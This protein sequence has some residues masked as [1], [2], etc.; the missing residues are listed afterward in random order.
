MKKSAQWI[1]G[2]VAA[3]VI[4]III[5]ALC[6]PLVINPNDYKNTITNLVRE[7]TGRTLRLPG[8]IKL[9]VSPSLD[10]IFALGEMELSSSPDFPDTP[11]LSSKS[12][13]TQLALWPLLAHK[14]LKVTHITLHGVN[15][16]LLR[17][18]QGDANWEDLGGSRQSTIQKQGAKPT[19]KQ[20]KSSEQELAGLD[21]GGIEATD[22]NVDF[23]DKQNDR[24]VS[25][26][27]L[28]LKIG[29][30]RPGQPFPLMTDFNVIMAAG[31]HKPLTAKI[32]SQ[33]DLT[34]FPDRQH[35]V[36]NNLKLKGTLNGAGLPIELDLKL[37]ADAD[38]NLRDEKIE[39]KN[40]VVK[41]GAMQAEGSLSLAGFSAPRASGTLRIPEFSPRAQ[42]GVLGLTLPFKDIK[43]LSRISAAMEFALD[44]DNLII[45]K[46]HLE[47]DDTSA[48]GTAAV[49]NLSDPS[50][51]LALH[52]NTI[53]LDR[54]SSKQPDK[55]TQR[56]SK[57]T[58][59]PEKRN[60]GT[61]KT[62]IPVDSIR[63]L[64]FNTDIIIDRLKAAKLTMS[65]VRIRATGKNG[66]IRLDPLS[67]HLYDG[68]L[69]AKGTIDARPD[70]PRMHLTKVLEG[71]RLGPLFRDWTGTEE[72]KGK[73]D[74]H[75]DV[76]TKGLTKKDLIKNA[77]GEMALSVA[78]GEIAKLRIISTIR[79]AKALIDHKPAVAESSEQ[80]TGF[81][82]LTATGVLRNGIFHN[83]DLHAESEV[84]TVDGKGTV[85]LVNE[86]IDYLLTIYLTRGIDRD[87]ETGLV[88]LNKTPI[89][90]RV[91]GNFSE[92][93]Q[94]AA[95]KK[96]LLNEGK[97]ALL[98]ILRKQ[99]TQQDSEKN[100]GQESTND[101]GSLMEQGIR[102]LFG[103]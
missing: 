30:L 45:N 24:S 97:K 92:I 10:V 1:L 60:R 3:I 49:N 7:K 51:D 18:S 85:D 33:C 62:L 82:K 61:A 81:A 73:A 103:K 102:S 57:T 35:F 12:V 50:Y 99:T 4:L 98:D 6:L 63:G 93:N 28:N 8:N 36:I 86:K 95:L 13:E 65:D 89:P 11:F 39:L 96:I 59:Q 75:V 25:L 29:R 77:N 27:N 70:V 55:D 44:P 15:L 53:D 16:H 69:T 14:E 21:I 87:K 83:N 76:V 2:A 22:I 19:K 20:R 5:A 34:L 48:D 78:D 94:S 54:Y 41:H 17:N 47:L 72:I 88:D 32:H 46:I 52:V 101:T 71:V 37:S 9:R 58:Q 80:K 68:T 84:M 79:A 23:I 91:R 42:L 38:L 74:I 64:T 31:R 66:Q 67:A 56:T 26:N 90:Y 40:L 43:A 100:A